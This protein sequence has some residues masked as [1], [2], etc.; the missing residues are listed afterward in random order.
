[1]KKKGSYPRVLA[2]RSDKVI[3]SWRDF[4]EMKLARKYRVSQFLK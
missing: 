3:D 2:S 1:M 4:Q